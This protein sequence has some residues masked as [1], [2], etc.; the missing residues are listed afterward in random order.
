MRAVSVSPAVIVCVVNTIQ[1]LLLLQ[2]SLR[3]RRSALYLVMISLRVGA[4]VVGRGRRRGGTH[5]RPRVLQLAQLVALNG[6]C[7]NLGADQERGALPPPFS[8]PWLGFRGL[9][10]ALR[11]GCRD[12]FSFQGGHAQSE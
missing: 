11:G 5:T 3:V 12:L 1:G 9:P 10:V 4:G 6:S 7:C 8:S 2:P